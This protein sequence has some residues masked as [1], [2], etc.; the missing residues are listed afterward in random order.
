MNTE[1]IQNGYVIGVDGGGTGCRVTLATIEGKVLGNG[2]GGSANITTNLKGA[3]DNIMACVNLALSE[4][5][6]TDA[7]LADCAA[8]LGLAGAN[9][10][11]FAADLNATLPF[12][13]CDI[14]SD[15]TIALQGALG[16]GDGAIAILGT[17]S[18]Y[19]CRT[20]TATRLIGGW[21][22]QLSDVGGGARLGREALEM[23]LLAHDEV[24]PHTELTQ[25]ILAQFDN[26]PENL[27]LFAQTAK[28]VD[29][30]KFAPLIFECA[31]KGD[32]NACTIVKLAAQNVDAS[33]D[34]ITVGGIERVALL[35]G[36][37]KLFG[38]SLSAKNRAL[39]VEPEANALQG[40]VDLARKLASHGQPQSGGP[41]R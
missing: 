29:Y 20:G 38:P 30:G 3:R 19:M 22:F 4:A 15:A 27:T 12:A 10:G 35:G 1:S 28:P 9:V 7:V 31:A 33:L 32:S 37:A 23:T 6:L 2:T 8:V 26:V 21:G 18:A 34:A 39:L 40:A 25:A 24:V 14:V 11:T 41:K 16:D 36:L 5:N 17:G 13:L